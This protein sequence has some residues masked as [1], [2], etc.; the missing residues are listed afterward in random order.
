MHIC[1]NKLNKEGHTQIWSWCQANLFWKLVFICSTGAPDRMKA[2]EQG[3]LSLTFHSLPSGCFS[4]LLP[5]VSNHNHQTETMHE[6]DDERGILGVPSLVTSHPLVRPYANKRP[7]F[8][9]RIVLR[10]TE[11][12]A[13]VARP[14]F[15][16]KRLNVLMTAGLTNELVNSIW[17]R[18]EW[19]RETKTIYGRCWCSVWWMPWLALIAI[20]ERKIVI[21]CFSTFECPHSNPGPFFQWHFDG[22]TF[23]TQI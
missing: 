11:K 14:T 9:F 13:L 16:I 5:L 8:F 3:H 12:M 1:A 18:N 22:S 4:P 7:H 6:N 2:K 23:D 19:D 17:S 20:A 10:P 21:N 15:C